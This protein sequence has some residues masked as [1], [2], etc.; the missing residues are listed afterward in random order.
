MAALLVEEKA[1]RAKEAEERA[2]E[3][4]RIRAE[5]AAAAEQAAAARNNRQG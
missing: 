2:R 4:A 5:K 1:R 3:L